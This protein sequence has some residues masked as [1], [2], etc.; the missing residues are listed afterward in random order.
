MDPLYSL[1]YNW[2][3]RH[4]LIPNSANHPVSYKRLR[5]PIDRARQIQK[6]SSI[7]LHYLIPKFYPSRPEVLLIKSH[8]GC[9]LPSKY[10]D[11]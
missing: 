5:I 2:V 7:L 1:R 3:R 6:S 11:G 9:G 10:Q 4:E 8:S